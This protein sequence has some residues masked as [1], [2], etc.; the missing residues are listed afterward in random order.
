L[1][2]EVKPA[3]VDGGGACAGSAAGMAVPGAGMVS[4]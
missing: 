1:K 3:S 4:E 2:S